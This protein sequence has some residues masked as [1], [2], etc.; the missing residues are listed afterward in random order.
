MK[1]QLLERFQRAKAYTLAVSNAMPEENYSFKPVPEVWNFADLINHISYGIQWWQANYI[2]G[3]ELEWEPQVMNNDKKQVIKNLNT[4]F[5]EFEEVCQN[6]SFSNNAE[7][8]G[9]HS[10]L[11]HVTHH[12]A[13][14]V[15]Y[16]R[17]KGIVPPEYIY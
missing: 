17:C 15:V 4:V 3:E 9:F 2:L 16:L 7:I 12:R 13:Q 8:M 1:T 5:N 10:T 6:I 14:A 11:D